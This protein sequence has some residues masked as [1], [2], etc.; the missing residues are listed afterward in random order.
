M[1]EA[2]S[3]ETTPEA[4]ADPEAG[5]AA[6]RLKATCGG[7]LR[8]PALHPAAAAR[9]SVPAPT[10]K[11]G[12]K[13]RTRCSCRGPSV[14]RGQRSP[15][16]PQGAEPDPS[17]RVPGLPNP[18]SRRAA[19]TCAP[20]PHGRQEA[21]ARCSRLPRK[22]RGRRGRAEREERQGRGGQGSCHVTP[23]A[24]PPSAA[25]SGGGS[26]RRGRLGGPQ[27][28]WMQSL[29]EEESG[30]IESESLGW[31]VITAAEAAL[32]SPA[33]LPTAGA[34]ATPPLLGQVRGPKQAQAWEAG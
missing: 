11:E 15:R 21:P 12:A 4:S 32:G 23:A 3:S 2:G 24:R 10:P 28:S 19:L 6:S 20:A 5:C 34:V 33:P 27:V 9:G 17:R 26:Q 29:V 7:Q 13:G 1:I 14:A 8:S 22:R 18:R 16:R 25:W 30:I 31:G